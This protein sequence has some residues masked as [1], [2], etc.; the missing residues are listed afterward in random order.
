MKEGHDMQP[1]T[2]VKHFRKLSVIS[3]IMLFAVC[4]FGCL[5]QKET[6]S[7]LN[8]TL[9][10]AQAQEDREQVI[11][12]LEN[13]HPFF[14]LEQ[15]QKEY[16]AAKEKYVK[17]TKKAMPIAEFREITSIYLSSINDGHTTI[18]WENGEEF[19][20]LQM[21]S[22][23]EDGKTYLCENGRK[24]DMRI[25]GIG[26]VSVQD[27]Y[28]T[29]DLI[30]PEENQSAMAKNRE[31]FLV[32]KSVLACCGVEMKDNKVQVLFSDGKEK[33]YSFGKK[34][35]ET[36]SYG[37]GENNWYKEGDIFVIDLNLCVVDAKLDLIR[38]ELGRAINTG[39]HKI[40]IDVRG[41]PGGDS[42]ACRLL[43]NELG[44]SIPD[45]T[46]ICR[47]SSFAAEQRGYT[48]K[49]GLATYKESIGVEEPGNPIELVV[50][51]DK[52]TFS[53]ATLLCTWVRDGKLGKIIGE[54]SSNQPNAYGDIL[55][56]KLKNSKME[57]GVS[58]KKFIRP[59]RYRE[60]NMLIPDIETSA[61]DAY[62][63][64][65]EY[66]KTRV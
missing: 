16:K 13:V 44:L 11:E 8:Q 43:L 51:S 24:T 17:A 36:M 33:Q 10:K 5:I 63:Q 55:V 49:E 19:P 15:N 25:E 38:S 22:R 1:N 66:L 14:L 23:Y 28:Q 32:V 12:Y 64:G 6:N 42:E 57:I 52:Y 20:F 29:I 54:A 56:F 58:H 26:G 39:C 40:M 30:R 45:M 50:L 9:T 18:K 65:I 34:R 2:K 41:N 37:V 62:Q 53:S 4:Q 61:E 3:L 21:E 47:Y 35:L 31:R 46:M 60:E 27:I 59:D 48:E 7:S